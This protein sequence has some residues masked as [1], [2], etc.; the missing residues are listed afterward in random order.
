MDSSSSETTLRIALIGNPNTGKSTLFS[1]LSGIRQRTGNYPGVT[2]EKRV[3]LSC[4]NNLEIEW[5]DLPGTYSLVPRSP[6]EWIAVDVLVGHQMGE[7]RP[8]GVVCVLDASNLERNLFLLSQL[9]D[10]QIPVVVALNMVD[11]ATQ[12]GVVVDRHSL[13]EQ[14]GVPVV[15]TQANKRVGIDE[16]LTQV[17]ELKNSAGHNHRV[18][19]PNEF[20]KVEQQLQTELSELDPPQELPRFLLQRLLL[21]DDVDARTRILGE[22]DAAKFETRLGEMRTALVSEGVN[23]TSVEATARYGW[24]AEVSRQAVVKKANEVVL[25]WADRLDRVLVHKVWG[26]LIFLALMLLVFQSIFA[27]A[28]PLMGLIESITGWVGE[29]AAAVLPDGLLESLVVDG[30]IAGVGGVLVF[31][32]QILILFFFIG[33]LEDC[34][35]MARAAFLMDRLM[36]KIGLNGKSFI[37]LLSS[38]ACAIP[39]IMA[40]RTIENPR[41]R[42]ITILVA[43]LMSCSA[44]LPVYTVLIAAF[45][46]EKT[47]LGGWLGLQGIVM[48]SMYMLGILVAIGVAF[49]LKQTVLRGASSPFL[50]ELPAFKTPSIKIVA[51]RMVER[52]GAFVKRAGT[53]ILSVTVLVWA[54]ATFPKNQATEA[55]YQ[56][57]MQHIESSSSAVTEEDLVVLENRFAARRLRE[58]FLGQAG[59]A[60]EPV[61]RPLGWDWKIG[62]AVLASFPAREVVIGTMGVIYQLG[63]EQDEESVPLREALKRDRW[64][65]TGQLVFNVPVALSMMVFFALCAQ[66]ASTLVVIWRETASW[67]WPIFTFAYMTG[68]AYLAA[69]LTFQIGSRWV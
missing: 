7:P 30:V 56:A 20:E 3:G 47:W 44:R 5:I 54:A 25:T 33:V 68:L 22:R 59:Q 48:F 29:K 16:L 62:C 51:L 23:L 32:P 65:S 38:F 58:S 57:A 11:L 31:L 2:V 1:R 26:T 66:C 10:L 15:A 4:H 69:Y 63:G 34:G 13:S 14:L 12:H 49:T 35:Y 19:F 36:A 55:E 60:V 27:W 67:R 17:C 37:P 61:V 53:L 40:T 18:S 24:I 39:G 45:I 42:L 46:P 64:E 8:D 41:D 43:P 6:D 28:D 9:L 21:Q 50:L 52:G